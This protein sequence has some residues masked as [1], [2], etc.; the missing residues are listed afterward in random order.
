MNEKKTIM[1]VI[2]E[3]KGKIV[4]GLLIGL[5]SIGGILIAAGLL[6]NPE[7]E[8]P[9]EIDDAIDV[10]FEEENEENEEE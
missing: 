2:K 5:A 7:D 4:K 1:E 3:N 9:E 8:E 6:S 10:E